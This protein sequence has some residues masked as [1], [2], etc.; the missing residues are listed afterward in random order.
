MISMTKFT[1]KSCSRTGFKWFLW[2][3]QLQSLVQGQGL[4]DFYDKVHYKVL[5]Q[6]QGLNDFY[7]KVHYNVL[8]LGQGLNDFYDKVNYKVLFKDRV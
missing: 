4:N 6:G 1:T 2:Q 5:F 8:F 3:S 7:D